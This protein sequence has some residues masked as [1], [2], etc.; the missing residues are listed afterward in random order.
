MLIINSEYLVAPLF[1]S[2]NI[3]EK[4]VEDLRIL[5]ELIDDESFQVFKECNIVEEMRVLDF[6]PSDAHFKKI[7]SQDINSRFSAND[8]VRVLFRLLNAIPEY[9]NIIDN[10][11]IEWKA[12]S[13]DPILS[14]LSDIRKLHYKDLFHKVIFQSILST[15]G[16]LYFFASKK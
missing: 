5:N 11:E 9:S 4:Y 10:Y 15:A 2:G 8:I 16:K 14:Y 1:C 12:Q 3:L 6:Y 7:I 13:T